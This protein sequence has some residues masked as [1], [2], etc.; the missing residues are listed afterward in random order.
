MLGM[1]IPT[2]QNDKRDSNHSN[3]NSNPSKA[4][5]TILMQIRTIRMKFHRILTIWMQI[6]SIRTRFEVIERK[7]E[8]I[9]EFDRDST[10]SNAHWTHSKA[11]RSTSM[12]I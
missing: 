8:L 11:I 1:Q 7:L 6:R 5:L 12:Q 4:I 3:P 2:I 10:H 9:E